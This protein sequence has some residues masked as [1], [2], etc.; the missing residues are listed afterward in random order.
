MK[1][2][3]IEAGLPAWEQAVVESRHG[4]AVYIAD[5]VV[6]PVPLI[7]ECDGKQHD[8]KQDFIRDWATSQRGWTTLRFSG[9]SI[10]RDIHGCVS[11]IREVFDLLAA[12][13]IDR[14]VPA[15][16]WLDGW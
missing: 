7:V 1:S 9:Y 16:V 3:L 5:F 15:Q 6:G 2:A 11:R 8:E 12:L 10:N 14:T 4:R 13:A